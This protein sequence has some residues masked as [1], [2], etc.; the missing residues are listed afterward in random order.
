MVF[1][2]SGNAPHT[3]TEMKVRYNEKVYEVEKVTDD[4]FIIDGREVGFDDVVLI[5]ERCKCSRMDIDLHRDW[6]EGE[7]KDGNV[8]VFFEALV[9]YDET[10]DNGVYRDCHSVEVTKIS[11][12]VDDAFVKADCGEYFEHDLQCLLQS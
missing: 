8:K 2:S 7:H 5:V 12:E 1:L 3:D 6:C 11:A 4:G 10:F 9:D